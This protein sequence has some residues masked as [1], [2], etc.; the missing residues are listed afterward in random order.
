[1]LLSMAPAARCCQA[2]GHQESGI[3]G[4]AHIGAL[5][6]DLGDRG[7]VETTEVVAGLDPVHPVLGTHR[8]TDVQPGNSSRRT[9]P[10]AA[11]A[12]MAC[13][14]GARRHAVRRT[15]KPRPP[16]GGP[17]AGVDGDGG[18]GVGVVADGVALWPTQGPTTG[19][20]IQ[21][22]ITTRRP[23]GPQVGGQILSHVEIELRLA[24]AAVGGGAGRVAGLLGAPVEDGR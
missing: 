7:Q 2:G 24:V 23:L 14:I 19:V 15:A 20:R 8:F 16:A 10:K 17:H 3:G 4:V 13:A 21:R 18:V 22:V 12:P 11:E 1:M 5:Y 6:E 9:V